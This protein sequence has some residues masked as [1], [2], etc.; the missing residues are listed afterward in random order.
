[1][2]AAKRS[3]FFGPFEAGGRFVP[4]YQAGAVW[5]SGEPLP[6]GCACEVGNK[7]VTAAKTGFMLYVFVCP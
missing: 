3:P 6:W 2:D 5:I 7:T 1:M 4:G